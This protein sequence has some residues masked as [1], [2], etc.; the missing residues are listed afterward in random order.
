MQ[1]NVAAKLGEWGL[2][3]EKCEVKNQKQITHKIQTR[4]SK[5]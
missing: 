1:T 3:N 4:N 2:N 5:S